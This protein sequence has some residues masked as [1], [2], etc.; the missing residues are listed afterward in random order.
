MLT[1]RKCL[2]F[3]ILL[4]FFISIQ[5]WVIKILQ[6]IFQYVDFESFRQE[7]NPDIIKYADL[8]LT[9]GTN[10]SVINGAV[11]FN[12]VIEKFEISFL[13]TSPK[14]NGKPWTLLNVT[15][16]GCDFI[17]NNRRK[18]LNFPYLLLE[19]MRA[20]TPNFPKKCPMA[21]VSSYCQNQ[22]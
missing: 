18:K 14:R 13:I 21:K 22:N 1:Y 9:N 3:L 10:R 6:T 7:Y 2:S 8:H 20:S 4:K 11:I 12:K 16:N 19:E 17:A 5:S 15:F